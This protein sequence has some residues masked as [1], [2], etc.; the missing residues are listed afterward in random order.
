MSGRFDTSPCPAVHPTADR[1]LLRRKSITV[2][3]DKKTRVQAPEAQ[4]TATVRKCAPRWTRLQHTALGCF[5][6]R[7]G[8]YKEGSGNHLLP[9]NWLVA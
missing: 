3:L 9:G 8:R 7:W 6:P 5:W 1:V 2:R 4:P